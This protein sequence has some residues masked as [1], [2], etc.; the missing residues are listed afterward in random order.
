LCRLPRRRQL[1]ESPPIE[2][3][4]R[5]DGL[6]WLVLLLGP[7]LVLQRQLHHEI[8]AIFLLLTRRSDIALVL[9]SL[10]FF[11]GVL[12]HELSHFI[13]AR[14]SAVRTGRFSLI[15]QPL[16]NGRL[17]LGY[18]ETAKTDIIRDALIGA[19]PLLAGGAIVAY[20]G[21][22]QLG[23]PE[24]W[25]AL[26]AGNTAGWW[27][28]LVDLY[29]RPDFWLWFYLTFAISSTM[30]PSASDRRAW[31]PMTLVI[32][33]LLGVGLLAGVGPWMAAHLAPINQILRSIALVFAVGLLAH[34]VLWPP[35]RLIHQLLA[36]ATGW[37]VVS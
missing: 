13:V 30:M 35:F 6:W 23:L 9:F 20:A 22:Y 25:S 24:L 8:Q 21:I 33:A 18:V 7:F 15:P 10:V 19:A 29:H 11:P 32:L 2:Q 27:L 4:A 26:R 16:E 3:L 1:E 36:H 14:L 17:Q 12:V 5:L 28:P 31:L 34:L 37:D